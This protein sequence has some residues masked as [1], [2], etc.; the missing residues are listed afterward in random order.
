M[1]MAKRMIIRHGRCGEIHETATACPNCGAPR[2]GFRNASKK[3]VAGLLA[4][5]VVLV[6][7][8]SPFL[9]LLASPLATGSSG[10]SV[11]IKADDFLLGARN[12][13]VTIVEYASMT[14]PHCANFDKEVMPELRKN[15]IDT[16]KV[17]LIFREYPLDGAARMAAAVARC[18]SGD[19]YFS[20]SICYSVPR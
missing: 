5:L 7:G 3:L 14:C 2:P 19:Q 8:L 6:L 1:Q 18:L 15:Y 20:S 11:D 16:G 9:S 13:P 10:R 4:I 12:A 17:K